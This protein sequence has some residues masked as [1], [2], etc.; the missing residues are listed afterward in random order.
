MLGGGGLA[1]LAIVR[2][3]PKTDT[4]TY[5]GARLS[6][7]Q[8]D[9]REACPNVSGMQHWRFSRALL[10][11][12]HGAYSRSRFHGGPHSPALGA[13]ASGSE[14]R[15]WWRIAICLIHNNWMHLGTP[16]KAILHVHVHHP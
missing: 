15:W 8:Y 6:S 7:I 9:L 1:A 2:G 12:S 10:R 5:G 14:D 3:C 11:G 13:Q 16:C 4:K